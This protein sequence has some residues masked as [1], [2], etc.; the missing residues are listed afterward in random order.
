LVGTQLNIGQLDSV[1]KSA[2]LLVAAQTAIPFLVIAFGCGAAMLVFGVRW[3]DATFLRDGVVLATAGAMTSPVAMRLLSR[4][5]SPRHPVVL[6]SELDEI[7]GVVGLTLL[8][9][10]FRPRFL[11]STWEI[12]GT[13]WLFVTL[14]MGMTIGI[15]VYVVLRRPAT[16]S[17]FLT[18]ALGSVAF[19]AGLAAFVHLS[20]IVVCFVAGVL[21][22]NLPGD[23]RGPLVNTLRRIERPI[24]FVFLVLAGALWKFTDWHGWVL[25]AVFV[26]TR[27]VGLFIAAQVAN[28]VFEQALAG[29]PPSNLVVAPLSVLSI[30]IVVSAQN[31]YRSAAMP[32]IVTAVI[33][34]AIATEI[35]S[36][37]RRRIALH[38]I[39]PSSP[40]ISEP[41]DDEMDVP[42]TVD[43]EA[44]K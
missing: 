27:F 40:G 23:H 11:E 7:A 26:A 12:P 9:A 41:P 22:A 39:E 36:Q 1:P 2:G 16:P 30:A 33:G 31:L 5:R 37:L 35:I 14:G 43:D 13:A 44:W 18:I 24:Y 21:V 17:E 20:P 32:W 6:A 3:S 8:G 42:T 28:R 29:V 4:T 38:E 19:T 10:Y 25:M 15:V 34:G